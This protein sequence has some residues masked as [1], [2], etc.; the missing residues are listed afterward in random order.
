MGT[1]STTTA[2]ETSTV[3]KAE[4]H[5]KDIGTD[6]EDMLFCDLSSKALSV[7]DLENALR[8]WTRPAVLIACRN[9]LDRLP[10]NIPATVL[11]LDLSWN[12]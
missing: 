10:P 9:A 6:A 4:Q 1:S 3:S 11:F 7:E 8:L 12:R 5:I 2:A